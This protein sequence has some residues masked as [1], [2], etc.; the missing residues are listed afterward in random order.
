MQSIAII[1]NIVALCRL[2]GAFGVFEMFI[3]RVGG[4]NYFLSVGGCMSFFLTKRIVAL[5]REGLHC[6]CLG[7]CH[8]SSIGQ[9]STT[10]ADEI[11]ELSMMYWQLL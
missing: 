5:F 2:G 8:C 3:C 7:V 4:A 6:S 10:I 11:K 1:I 9:Q